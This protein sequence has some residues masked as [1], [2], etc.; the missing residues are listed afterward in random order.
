ME[1]IDGWIEKK[2]KE[3]R[4]RKGKEDGMMKEAKECH[5]EKL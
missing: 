4:E 2:K 5:R 3:K 1:G